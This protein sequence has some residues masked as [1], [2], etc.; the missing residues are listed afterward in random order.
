MQLLFQSEAHWIPHSSA[1]LVARVAYEP[2]LRR[3]FELLSRSLDGA[4][5][6]T[7]RYWTH[8]FTPMRA[9][10]YYWRKLVLQKTIYTQAI[11]PANTGSGS[12]LVVGIFARSEWSKETGNEEG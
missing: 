12:R 4:V 7:T 1:L 9:R 6:R 10:P 5:S 8:P 2:G 3:N 11:M